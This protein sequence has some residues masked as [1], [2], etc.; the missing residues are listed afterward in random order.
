MF[1]PPLKGKRTLQAGGGRDRWLV[2]GKGLVDGREG[3]WQY[4]AQQSE[5]VTGQPQSLEFAP[6]R[7]DTVNQCL[8]R[9]GREA[10]ERILLAP[11]AF[12]VLR[13]LV[14][15]PGRLVTHTELL[16]A[17]WPKTYVQPEVLKSHIAAIR[18]ALGDDAR[19]PLF[20]ETMLRR[21]YR[22]IAPVTEAAPPTATAAGEIGAAAKTNLPESVSE[23][24]G[25]EAELR[26]VA[27]L[28][29]ELRLVSLVGP[30]GIGKT[31]LVLEVA[32][33]LLPR[34]PDGVFVAELGP[35]SSPELVPAT[36][37]SALGLT[38]IVGADLRD[39]VARAVGSKKLLLV[40]D[41]CEHV[42]EAAAGMAEALLRASA[43]AALLVTSREPLR[44]SGEYLYRVPPLDVPAEDN[45]DMKDV[46]RYGAVRL[47]VSRA[48]AADPR[49][50]SEGHVAAA[51]AT[52][53][54]RLDGIPLAIELAATRIIAFGVDGVAAGLD[55]RLRLLTGGSRTLARQ[56]TMRAT[57][58]WSYEL[59][60]ESERVVFRRLGMFVGP[61]TMD[62]AS[63]VAAGID[64]PA[65]E[66]ADSIADL[67]AK[68]LVSTDV[69]GTIV[70]YRLLE[71][72]RAYAREKLIE[73]AEIEVVA[74]RHAEYFRDLFQHAE[75]DLETRPTAE[76]LVAYRSHIDNLRAALDWAFSP[77]GDVG[78]G[79]ELTAATVPLWM[80]LLLPT[81]CGARVEQAIASLGSR[82]PG[83]PRRDMRLYLALGHARLQ[84]T[85]EAAPRATRAISL[86]DASAA[87][88]K[89][90]EL[91]EV[92]DDTR[93][94]LGAI[95]RLYANRL[96]TGEYRVAL[97]LGETFHA[98]AARTADR[99]DVAIGSRLIGQALHILGDQPGA[100]RHLEPLIRSR[101]PSAR[102][103]GILYQYDERALLDTFYS[104]V[105]WL[106]GFG[107][108]AQ[109]LT[110]SLVDHARTKDHV[111]SFLYA[112]LIAACP[113]ALFVGDLT[114]AEHHV[115]LAVD[116]AT[117]H[118]VKFWSAWAQC[119][120]GALLIKRGDHGAGSQRLQSGLE[121]LPEP[122]ALHHHVSLLLAELAAGLG[123]AGKIAEGLGVVDKALA[124]AE[125]TES[126]WY[127]AELLRTK[128]ELLLLGG[129]SSA[130][131]TAE[132]CFQQAL[133]VARRQGALS[134]EL[135]AAMSLARL[136]RG[137]QRAS[138]ARKLLAPVYR[139]FTEGFGTTDLI[140]AKAL[141][142]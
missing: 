122:V 65:S 85:G 93:Y 72:T 78:V 105:L 83:D 2:F 44:V 73:S 117:R 126:R 104:R 59:L 128:G 23:L 136:W 13:Y 42:I 31:R 41:N 138:Q 94:R 63:A 103:L 82:V 38:H 28:A 3:G 96:A 33:R 64:V 127:L 98:I 25:R 112:L 107:D 40:I 58:D 11:R 62:A 69:V 54:R 141:L 24:I 115:R 86:Q 60:S 26:E 55:D 135:R 74:R 20:I 125:Q 81:E 53:C 4:F 8:W 129:A 142:A 39:G 10:E 121:R 108:Q 47:F 6:F 7:L 139:R 101:V 80:H 137:Q 90:L 120:E 75:A 118:A 37:A 130:V 88:E 21:G 113:I 14:E 68:S 79:V 52:I 133:D 18:A 70:H 34:F 76:W 87:F 12:D 71:T 49:Y 5:T 32:R 57:L 30:G 111:V 56:Q 1:A 89:A 16:D 106:Q 134:W 50:V 61:F 22:F 124:G 15:H 119:F 29:S 123:G 19:K 92:I 46:L 51:T 99:S 36:V 102:L 140:A 17:L 131:T 43:G 84:I 100:R 97:S 48:R 95:S 45:Q 116:L 35:L 91:A 114:T 110:E 27:A 66:V 77:S 109:R 9:D 67:V 132:Q